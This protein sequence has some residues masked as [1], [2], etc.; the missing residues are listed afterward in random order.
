MNRAEPALAF[1]LR[2]QRHAVGALRDHIG[3]IVD[4]PDDERRARSRFQHAA[5][6]TP[7]PRTVVVQPETPDDDQVGAALGREAGDL[8]VGFA[9]THV[10]A[11]LPV[12][13]VEVFERRQHERGHTLL[14]GFHIR[15]RVDDGQDVQV[16]RIVARHLVECVLEYDLRVLGAIE[17][18]DDLKTTAGSCL[19]HGRC[20]CIGRAACQLLPET[21]PFAELETLNEP[22][23]C[24]LKC[25]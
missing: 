2:A 8:L 3:G 10:E 5:G 20:D 6:D 16:W 23:T 11:Q 12:G 19:P 15:W 22:V 18:D 14:R 17:S 4:H 21:T 9:D 7:E 24:S 25:A 13:A 1:R